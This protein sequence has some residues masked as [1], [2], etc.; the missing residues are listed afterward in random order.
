MT[1]AP[2]TATIPNSAC[3]GK[4]GHVSSFLSSSGGQAVANFFKLY[5]DFYQ[6]KVPDYE[7][8]SLL[9][10]VDL[11]SKSSP[12]DDQLA[13]VEKIEKHFKVPGTLS[14]LWYQSTHGVTP[15]PLCV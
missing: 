3:L 12:V 5:E 11:T 13:L 2:F 9:I 4:V 15:F 8:P 14:H 6:H 1:L 10:F 7:R